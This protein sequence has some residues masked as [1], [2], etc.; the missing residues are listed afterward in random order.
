M[1]PVIAPEA[2]GEVIVKLTDN[3]QGAVASVEDTQ[4]VTVTDTLPGNTV[5]AETSGMSPEAAADILT[6]LPSV[7]YAEPNYS[8]AAFAIP[9]DDTYRDRLWALDNTG[10][11]VNGSTGTA[12]D[13]IDALNAW[14]LSLGTSTLVAI[15]DSGVLYAH[16]DLSANMW[17]GTSCVSDIGST[18]GGCIH[19]YDFADNDLDPAPVS[20]STSYAHGT[21]V[22]GIIAAA[23]NNGAGVIGIAPSSKVMAVRFGFDVA[24]EVRA[25]DFAR[26]NGAKIINA[27]YG[28]TQFSQAEYDAIQRFTNAGGIFVAAAGN[29][30]G[31][32]DSS[33]IYPA[34]YDLPGIV[35]VAATDQND[36]FA[37]FS[38]YGSTTVDLGAPG[39]NIASTY[40]SGTSTAAYAYSDG[41]SMA[42][43][44]V[45]GTVALIESLYPSLSVSD[46]KSALLT[47][48]EAAASL[49][50][51]TASGNRLN[52]YR[53]LRIAGG[54]DIF[55]PVIT[56]TGA[57][58]VSLNVGASYAELGA[59]AFDAHEGTTTVTIGGDIVNT[60]SAGTYHVTYDAVDLAGNHAVQVVRTV[61]V[62]VAAAPP[63]SGGGGGGGGGGGHSSSNVKKKSSTTATT[64]KKTSMPVVVD[65]PA[66]PALV[67]AVLGTTTAPAFQ[68]VRVLALGS[69]GADVTAL[70]QALARA[71]VYAGPVTGYFGPL[72]QAAV[73][74]YQAKHALAQVGFTGPM[75]RALLNQGI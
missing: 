40:V 25:I 10:Q 66:R 49:S 65:N 32:S 16:P 62:T 31:N 58:T 72:T 24:S 75:T 1:A 69:A 33:P 71:S 18:T 9:T 47:G 29:S 63:S 64:V 42:A 28:G 70:Q 15:I 19:G 22:A 68:F 51:T 8:R 17:D 60:S 27:S 4:G 53:A 54:A 6:D 43:P 21:H 57:S 26:Q 7:E 59:T 44:Y 13:D 48:G 41:T 46:I 67:Q 35:S 52:A 3:S 74:A 73:R 61:T 36:A 34:A 12:G 50:T 45:A 11:S 38:N 56:L 14:N 20:T 5:I 39:V 55:P 23:R 37:S 30:S 2:T